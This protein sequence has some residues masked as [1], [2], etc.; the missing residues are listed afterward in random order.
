ME[1]AISSK[2][3][4]KAEAHCG[5]T[6]EKKVNT[7]AG[8]GMRELEMERIDDRDLELKKSG[9]STHI[10]TGGGTELGASSQEDSIKRRAPRQGKTDAEILLPLQKGSMSWEGRM[11]CSAR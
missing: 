9:V 6:Q 7:A 5:R 10:P 3:G 11:T 2:R 8:T 4:R 1:L